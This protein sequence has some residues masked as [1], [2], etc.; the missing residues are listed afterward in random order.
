MQLLF[1]IK[2]SLAACPPEKQ[3]NI[4]DKPNGVIFLERQAGKL[5]SLVRTTFNDKETG[6]YQIVFSCI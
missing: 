5:K 3:H 2:R 6:K 4:T 1:D